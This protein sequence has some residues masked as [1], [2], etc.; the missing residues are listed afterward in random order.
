MTKALSTLLLSLVIAPLSAQED[1]IHW[2]NGSV[3]ERVTVTDYNLREIKYRKGGRVETAES[4]KVAD[5]FVKKVRD[6]Y[7]Q[8][9]G[10]SSSEKP[11][12]FLQYAERYKDDAFLAQFG[13]VEAIHLFE[14]A[15]DSGSM[16][17]ALDEM[18]KRYPDSGF[19]TMSFVTKIHYYLG[20]GKSTDAAKVALRYKNTATGQ[21]Y[22]AGY[23]LEAEFYETLTLGLT[24]ELPQ[25]QVRGV[26]E[27]IFSDADPDYPIIASRA[28][29]QIADS[30]RGEGK[31]DQAK[32]AYE[33]ILDQ[34]NL[35]ARIRG[36]AWLGLGHISFAAGNPAD[37]EPYGKA[38]KQFLRVYLANHDAAPAVVAESLEFGAKAAEK[39]GGT[40]STRISKRL[41]RT[42]AQEFPDWGK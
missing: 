26:M 12:T 39:W 23:M 9:F 22:L 1:R 6:K 41:Q 40:D 42:L 35:G 18:A 33:A 25:S 11:A 24:G 36:G 38:L 32:R 15:G 4:D 34:D 37:R 3:T 19:L 7:S 31:L 13:Y 14:K 28:R 17:S 2:T 29:L 5:L 8:A 27:R 30:L 21:G 16:F 20:L 10:A